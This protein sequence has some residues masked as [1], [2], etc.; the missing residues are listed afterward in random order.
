MKR[1]KK[2]NEQQQQPSR[3][4]DLPED[5]TAHILAMT[6]LTESMRFL[7]V[8]REQQSRQKLVMQ[9]RN[10]W[11]FSIEPYRTFYCQRYDEDRVERLLFGQ[12]VA[13]I[14]RSIRTNEDVQTRT[15]QIPYIVKLVVPFC[16][17]QRLSIL[18]RS[19]GLQ[20]L[21]LLPSTSYLN[22]IG[23]SDAKSTIENQLCPSLAEVD[24]KNADGK[25]A[26]KKKKKQSNEAVYPLQNI[27]ELVIKSW[28]GSTP[29]TRN[30]DKE[31]VNESVRKMLAPAQVQNFELLEL[32]FVIPLLPASLEA[33]LPHMSNIR[34]L[35]L[36]V[37]W[38]CPF[39]F[40]LAQH[41]H[42]TLETCRMAS[43]FYPVEEEAYCDAD[44]LTYMFTNCTHLQRLELLRARPQTFKVWREP[45]E[46]KWVL[47]PTLEWSSCNNS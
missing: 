38:R 33:A 27:H 32:T 26:E 20:V 8:D 7:Q 44:T 15:W 6:D 10:V 21:E 30:E 41:L 1:Q 31:G 24:A 42:R 14:L 4:Y 36:Q 47:F 34:H 28:N 2:D 12:S 29:V 46:D 9:S 40:Q 19:A 39:V 35:K 11:D 16:H 25:S 18:L 43:H 3:R 17:E 23:D 45:N 22:P 13:E 37:E 5:T